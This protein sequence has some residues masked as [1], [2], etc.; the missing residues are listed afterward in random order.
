M[1]CLTTRSSDHAAGRSI[2]DR[3]MLHL[4]IKCFRLA[5][6]MPRFVAQRER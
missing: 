3:E 1:V 6:P 4:R 5:A 2:E